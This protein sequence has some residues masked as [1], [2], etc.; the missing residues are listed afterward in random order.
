MLAKKHSPILKKLW[1]ALFI[2]IHILYPKIAQV[3][4]SI[5]SIKNSK[6]LMN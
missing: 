3:L 1:Q 5:H 2:Q 4:F 6:N